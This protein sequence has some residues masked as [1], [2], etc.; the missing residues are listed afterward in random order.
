MIRE[1]F[2]RRNASRFGLLFLVGIAAA[3]TVTWEQLIA[4]GTEFHAKGR[5][6]EAELA[7]RAALEKA[8]T[9]GKPGRVAT[10]LNDLG[11][12]LKMRGDFR[13]AEGLYRHSIS[14][15]EAT[16]DEPNLA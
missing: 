2:S 15:Q 4:S 16:T 5:Y 6:A 9:S 8:E 14:I 11:L 3:Q 1:T 10:S 13:E 12:V 7:F